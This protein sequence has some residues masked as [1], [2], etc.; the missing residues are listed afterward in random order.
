VVRTEFMVYQVSDD[1]TLGNM[2]T[3]SRVG[4][5]FP[6]GLMHRSFFSCGNLSNISLDLEKQVFL[7]EGER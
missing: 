1:K 7:L 2:V 5:D 6:T 3:Y 4:G